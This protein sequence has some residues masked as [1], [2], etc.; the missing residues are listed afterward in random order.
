MTSLSRYANFYKDQLYRPKGDPLVFQWKNQIFKKFIFFIKIIVLKFR[1]IRH[2]IDVKNKIQIS[3]QKTQGS[4]L[5]F[6]MI[7]VK[8]GVSW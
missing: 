1:C 6:K 4:P 8:V 7:F 2:P 3:N 5:G